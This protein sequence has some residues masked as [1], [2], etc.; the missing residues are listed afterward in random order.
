M[1]QL[2][3]RE[4]CNHCLIGFLLDDRTLSPRR[5]QTSLYIAWVLRDSF[6]VVGKEDEIYALY[7]QDMKDKD[8]V[9][10]NDPWFIPGAL[11]HFASWR[12]NI[13]LSHVQVDSISVWV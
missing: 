1:Q 5:I 9:Q 4:Q 13:R 12:P 6:Y 11:L 10:E 3:S 8:Y 2:E 7:F